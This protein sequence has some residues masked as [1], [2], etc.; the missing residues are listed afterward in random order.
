[1]TG[2][3]GIPQPRDVQFKKYGQRH[4]AMFKAANVTFA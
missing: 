3:G 2:F 1:M 4:A